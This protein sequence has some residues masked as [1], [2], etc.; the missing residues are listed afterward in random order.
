MQRCAVL[1][2]D[3][4][5]RRWSWFVAY[6]HSQ[7]MAWTWW[8]FCILFLHC[9]ALSLGT[10]SGQKWILWSLTTFIHYSAV[11]LYFQV[12][13]QYAVWASVLCS[14]YN[15]ACSCCWWAWFSCLLVSTETC[16]CQNQCKQPYCRES[17]QHDY[18]AYGSSDTE[19]TVCLLLTLHG[20][21]FS[22]SYLG[23]YE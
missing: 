2:A 16:L 17:W 5:W 15:I 20:L 19:K 1:F 12:T 7:C 3:V 11:A 14:W 23:H 10:V 13:F 8:S 6:W 22:V 4:R 9:V 21:T 18:G